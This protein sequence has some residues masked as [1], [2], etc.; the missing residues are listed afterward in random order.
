MERDFR[1]LK[2]ERYRKLKAITTIKLVNEGQRKCFEFIGR[3]VTSEIL[4]N[5]LIP[6]F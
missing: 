6:I 4:D 3:E 1:P 5:T 2:K